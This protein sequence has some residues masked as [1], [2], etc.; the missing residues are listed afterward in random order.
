MGG[1]YSRRMPIRGVGVGG[2]YS[3][4]MPIRGVGVG[5]AYSRRMPIRGGG[6]GWCLFE[7]LPYVLFIFHSYPTL[8]YKVKRTRKIL[9]Y[10]DRY[11]FWMVQ[12]VFKHYISQNRK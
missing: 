1:A 9:T 10:G 3:R 11:D 8:P 4:R 6:G 12:R 2:A 7:D 5:G